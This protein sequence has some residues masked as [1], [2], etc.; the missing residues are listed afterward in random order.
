M[1]DLQAT[2]NKTDVL[3]RT[4]SYYHIIVSS[5]DKNLAVSFMSASAAVSSIMKLG[6]WLTDKDGK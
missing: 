3:G 1:S 4:L 5:V 6:S 2:E